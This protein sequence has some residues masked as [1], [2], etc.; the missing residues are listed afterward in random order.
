[1]EGYMSTQKMSR[2]TEN[3]RTTCKR[4][5]VGNTAM[6]WTKLASEWSGCSRHT[7]DKHTQSVL[8]EGSRGETTLDFDQD[9]QFDQMPGTC[10]SRGGNANEAFLDSCSYDALDVGR[11]TER[12]TVAEA[13]TSLPNIRWVRRL[14]EQATEDVNSSQNRWNLPLWHGGETSLQWLDKATGGTTSESG[15]STSK[16]RS[17]QRNTRTF[18]IENRTYRPNKVGPTPE[19][20]G[21]PRAKPTQVRLTPTSALPEPKVTLVIFQDMWENYLK[22]MFKN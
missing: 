9:I 19:R 21:V 10:C 17:F 5:A 7:S 15:S 13:R 14:T 8:Y 12:L 18:T 11:S 20:Q 2:G 16:A 1:M 22:R 4:K 6:P 3:C